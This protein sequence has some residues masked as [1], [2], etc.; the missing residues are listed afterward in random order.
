MYLLKLVLYYDN[1]VKIE[2]DKQ[3][4]NITAAHYENHK[5]A[6]TNHNGSSNQVLKTEIRKLD[7]FIAHKQVRN[8]EFYKSDV[9]TNVI[10]Y[11]FAGCTIIVLVV[12]AFH[13]GIK[14]SELKKC[15]SSIIKK[16][17]EKY[18]IDWDPYEIVN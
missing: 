17:I 4:K 3:S 11:S 7:T 10:Y 12:F 14:R 9:N 2:T 15:R 5:L 6:N 1:E 16:R 18:S 8:I 13:S